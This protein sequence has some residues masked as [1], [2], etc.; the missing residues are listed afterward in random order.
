M[1]VSDLAFIDT[2]EVN[3]QEWYEFVHNFRSS[4]QDI[5]N[6]ELRL[7]IGCDKMIAWGGHSSCHSVEYAQQ[8]TSKLKFKALA[9]VLLQAP[10]LGIAPGW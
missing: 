6:G 4:F 5:R 1:A 3:V 8:T 9:T 7:V 2:L 10:I